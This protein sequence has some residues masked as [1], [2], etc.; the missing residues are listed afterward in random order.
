[1]AND[2]SNDN[3]ERAAQRARLEIL[4]NYGRRT[5]ATEN[6]G[7]SGV[8]ALA[9]VVLA[10]ELREVRAEL[11]SGNVEVAEVHGELHRLL[12]TA[13]TALELAH[14]SAVRFDG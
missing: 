13:Q 10:Y 7:L 6:K 3:V 12:G 1:M 8:V 9:S 2:R 14:P 4:E 11:A 5:L